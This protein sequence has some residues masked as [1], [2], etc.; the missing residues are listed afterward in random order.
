MF[1]IPWSYI[2][3][4]IALIGAIATGY[5]AVQHYNS[6]VTENVQ[7]KTQNKSL[8]DEKEQMQKN[9]DNIVQTV[10]K[11]DVMQNTVTEKTNT[12]I[13]E[14]HAAPITT[15]CVQS[16]SIGIALR[17]LSVSTSAPSPSGEPHQ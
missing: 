12:V 1:G 10:D 14:I 16:P 9:Y 17:S 6:V 4:F 8:K 15:N 13:K 2:G 5:F 11:N 7:L 3:I